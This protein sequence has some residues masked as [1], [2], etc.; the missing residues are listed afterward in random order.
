[1]A[2]HGIQIERGEHDEGLLAD[3]TGL[4]RMER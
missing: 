3:P 4:L 2:L 1:M